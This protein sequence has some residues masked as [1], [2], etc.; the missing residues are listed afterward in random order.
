M[1][2]LLF[3]NLI[4]NSEQ[5]QFNRVKAIK[6]YNSKKYDQDIKSDNLK[7]LSKYDEIRTFMNRDEGYG[8][9]STL[10]NYK[11]I[12]DYPQSSVVPFSVDNNGIPIFCFSS[13]S[14]HT[15]NIIENSR[16]SFC[17]TETNF[18]NA[19]DARI[20]FTGNIQK[21]N[22]SRSIELKNRFLQS[23]KGAIWANFG[24]FNMYEL[25]N[26][27]DISFNGGFAKVDRIPLKEYLNAEV[28]YFSIYADDVKEQIYKKFV[29]KFREYINK[30]KNVDFTKYNYFEIKKIDKYGID[31][32]LYLVDNRTKIFRVEFQ[33][34][35]KNKNMLL[36]E[37]Y[38][39]FN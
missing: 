22:Q 5:F 7:R 35:I 27:K 38:S 31:F 26:I 30:N 13:I 21:M 17:V 18:R 34:E 4:I 10:A 33:N 39:K 2:L 9:L 8:V 24:D 19:A 6:R 12:K 11:K 36:K 16:V 25:N 23:H 1:K 29:H 28:D 37:L 15:R 20:S 14:M 3:V 32:R